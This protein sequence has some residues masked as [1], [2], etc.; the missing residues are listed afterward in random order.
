MTLA[1]VLCGSRMDTPVD[2]LV[3]TPEQRT[4]RAMQAAGDLLRAHF[5]AQ[6]QPQLMFM[7]VR[8]QFLY[9]YLLL[10]HASSG[11]VEFTSTVQTMQDEMIAFVTEQVQPGKKIA[12]RKPT[13][14]ASVPS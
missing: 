1:C 4:H 11:D 12:D 5:V 6:H 3:D 7:Q 8:G 13:E 10:C 14:S 2:F 9:A